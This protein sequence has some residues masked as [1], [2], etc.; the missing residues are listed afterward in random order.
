M[1]PHDL[2][3]AHHAHKSLNDILGG[4]VL[5]AMINVILGSVLLLVESL[6]HTAEMDVWLSW[7]IKAGSIVVIIFGICNGHLAYQ[8]NK[9]EL[10]RLKDEQ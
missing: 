7:V 4:T 6:T 2:E 3:T 9:I 5:G 8:K 10:K 1:M